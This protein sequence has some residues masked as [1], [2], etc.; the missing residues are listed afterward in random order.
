M[1]RVKK[2][3]KKISGLILVLTLISIWGIYSYNED[4]ITASTTS[5]SNKKIEW[6]IKRAQNNEQP[7]LGKVNK[8]LI[9]KYNRNSYGK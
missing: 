2:I 6:G 9:D 4:S 3:I 8:E 5:I 7:D 1:I